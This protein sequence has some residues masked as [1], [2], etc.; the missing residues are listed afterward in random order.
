MRFP[1]WQI[2]VNHDNFFWSPEAAQCFWSWTLKISVISAK[3]AEFKSLILQWS[4][5]NEAK[6]INMSGRENTQHRSRIIHLLSVFFLNYAGFAFFQGLLL[7]VLKNLHA[8][9]LLSEFP[10]S[11]HYPKVIFSHHRYLFY[12]QILYTFQMEDRKKNFTN[13]KLHWTV[14]YSSSS[15]KIIFLFRNQRFK[16]LKAT[17]KNIMTIWNT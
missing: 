5:E 10:A 15:Q 8:T 6:R 1:G 13:S 11:F 17:K 4:C 16:S 14:L 2:E 9:V 7:L 3:V 12:L